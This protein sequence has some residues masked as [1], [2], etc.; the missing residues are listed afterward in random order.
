MEADTRP[1]IRD[2]HLSTDQRLATSIPPAGARLP[3]Q[4]DIGGLHHLGRLGRQV[5]APRDRFDRRHEPA[6]LD[7][8][9][10]T[11]A[12]RSFLV[13]WSFLQGHA[14]G[15]GGYT[16][17]HGFTCGAPAGPRATH[18]VRSTSREPTDMWS[19]TA[20]AVASVGTPAVC[21]GDPGRRPGRNQHNVA[22]ARM[23]THG[24]D[25]LFTVK[26]HRSA[27]GQPRG[28]SHPEQWRPRSA[29]GA[30]TAARP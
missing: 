2:A 18:G 21:P 30:P 12:G 7:H 14:R 11:V 27:Q 10:G 20:T 8:A 22:R 23:R 19:T 1:I 6:G 24:A 17:R 9:E 3:N 5:R 15:R 13:H 25:Y 29:F 26:G 4:L 28:S 16:D